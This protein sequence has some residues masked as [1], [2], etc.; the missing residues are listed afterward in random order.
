MK[1]FIL[2]MIVGV[3]L[4]TALVQAGSK[5]TPAQEQAKYD[6]YRQRGQQL[7]TETIRKAVEAEQAQRLHK[8]PC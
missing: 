4:T 5:P 7:D 6:Y 1:N 8:K 3:L 2:G